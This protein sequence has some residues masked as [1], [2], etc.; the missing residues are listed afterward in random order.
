MKD[1]K[2]VKYIAELSQRDR[3]RLRQLVQS[4][5]FNQHK[6]TMDLLELILKSVVK[7]DAPLSREKVY[8]KVF[9]KSEFDEQKL[10]NVISNLKKLFHR[11]LAID[12]IEKQPLLEDLK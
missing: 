7:G 1:S 3:E 8:Q 5:F 6:P 12:H 9:P 4:P 10:H 2:L 11:F